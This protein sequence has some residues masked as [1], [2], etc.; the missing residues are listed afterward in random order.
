[1]ARSEKRGRNWLAI[2]LVAS[3]AAN[4]FFF[5][6]L[7]TEFLHFRAHRDDSGPHAA[8]VELRWLRGRL[9]PEAVRTV[10]AALESLRPDIVARIG[11]L[12]TLRAE[13]GALVAAAE[14]DRA[15]IDTHLRE[16]RLEVGAMQ[17]RIQSKTF[18]SVLALPPAERARLAPS[19][20]KAN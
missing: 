12:R 18:E 20:D 8:R 15:A 16:I 6:S 1:M 13:L 5:G 7:L 11:R 4:A 3:L 17:E 14:P 2:A 10:E 19:P 9:S